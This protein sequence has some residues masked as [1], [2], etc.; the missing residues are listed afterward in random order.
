MIAEA[1]ERVIRETR[2][3]WVED[4]D[5]ESFRAINS[6]LCEEFALEVIGIVGEMPGAPSPLWEH[7]SDMCVVTSPGPQ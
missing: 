5:A 7:L 6:G 4:G 1:V 3:R 2:E